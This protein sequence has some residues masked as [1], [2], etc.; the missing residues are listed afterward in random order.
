MNYIKQLNEF[1]ST[2]DYKP[3]SPNAIAIYHILLHIANKAGWIDEVK[4]ANLVLMSKC[5]I[6]IDILKSARNELKSKGYIDYTKGKNQNDAPKYKI[7]K[8]YNTQAETQALPPTLTQ[9]ETQALPHINKQN[10][11]KHIYEQKQVLLDHF[12]LIWEQYPNK[13]GKAKALEYYFQWMKGRKISGFTKKLTDEQMYRAV[14]RYKKEC[15][16]KRIEMQFVK[17]GDTFFNKAILDY[18]E[19]KNE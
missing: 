6:S 14:M 10:K 19:V 3:L 18:V 9:A 7:T 5:N 8:L 2:I 17:H 15:E 4:V 1:Y 12:E 13:K 11:T 16:E